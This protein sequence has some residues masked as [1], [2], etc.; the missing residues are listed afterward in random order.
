MLI[1]VAEGMLCNSGHRM[2]LVRPIQCVEK[3]TGGV[4][5]SRRTDCRKSELNI[6]PGYDAY[7]GH[8]KVTPKVTVIQEQRAI[9]SLR[10]IGL[11]SVR[12]GSL[13]LRT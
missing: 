7:L 12:N 2:R 11:T 3:G 1:R 6:S 8:D 5:N 4:S 13:L 10:N 9:I